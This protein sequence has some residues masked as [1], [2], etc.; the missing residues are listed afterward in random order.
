M[1]GKAKKSNFSNG[2]TVLG[3]TQPNSM[4]NRLKGLLGAVSSLKLSCSL[5]YVICDTNLPC[6][7]A[8]R[9]YAYTSECL[10]GKSV[11]PVCVVVSL[12]CLN[13]IVKSLEVRTR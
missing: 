1:T 2:I 10:T 4:I 12:L 11:R 7:K 6:D 9:Y 13:D 5:M 8:V 3:V